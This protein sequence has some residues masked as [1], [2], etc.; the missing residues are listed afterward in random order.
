MTNQFFLLCFI[1]VVLCI[2]LKFVLRQRFESH[3]V[4]SLKISSIEYFSRHIFKR[5]VD[6]LQTTTKRLEAELLAGQR[7]E[8]ELHATEKKLRENV[9]A[10]KLEAWRLQV[11]ESMLA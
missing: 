10:S 8:E 7:R 5:H 4:L 3:S 11:E 2:L 9:A 1:L 6:S